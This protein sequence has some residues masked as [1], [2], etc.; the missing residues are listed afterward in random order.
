MVVG[1]EHQLI[2][3]PKLIV[4]VT[5]GMSAFTLLRGQ[6]RWFAQHGYEVVL[7]ANDDEQALRA[8]QK[9][10]VRLEGIPMKREISMIADL[11]SLIKWV[12][13]LRKERPYALNVG[14]PKAGLLGNLAAWITRVPRRIYTVRG[15]RLEGTSGLLRAVLWISERASTALATDVVVISDSLGR[16]M[17]EFRL[18][19]NRK[20]HLIGIGSSNGI[21][22]LSIKE[23]V[24]RANPD[25]LRR[26][27]GISNGTFVVGFIGRMVRDKGI[28]TLL[29]AMEQLASKGQITLLMV[30]PAEEEFDIEPLKDLGIPVHQVGWTDD[31]WLYLSIIDVLCFPTIREGFGN[32]VLEAAAARVPAI[33][34]RA[35]GAVDTV[36]DNETGFVIDV[37]DASALAERIVELMN[38]SNL[39]NRLGESAADRVFSEFKPERIWQGLARVIDGEPSADIK[40]FEENVSGS[41]RYRESR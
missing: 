1:P 17:L 18:V 16:K 37:G 24:A 34:T 5:S 35:T 29:S 21:D 32:V 30:G 27:L 6:L 19:N 7:V 8:S 3:K 13:V 2:T 38:D 40:G 22:A 33:V 11:R 39:Q 36:V 20:M 31:P 28:D 41:S 23:R 25:S 26:D 15:L 9:E 12:K 10:G 4:A 14:T